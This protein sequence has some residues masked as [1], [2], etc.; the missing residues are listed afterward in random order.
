MI[1]ETDATSPGIGIPLSKAE[2]AQLMLK[3]RDASE[4]YAK[5]LE[6]L[7]LK[8]NRMTRSFHAWEKQQQKVRSLIAKQE[9]IRRELN[10]GK[11]AG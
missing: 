4:A 5:E 10:K 11:A 8:Q 1:A 6:K 2:K 9:A 3:L 7:R